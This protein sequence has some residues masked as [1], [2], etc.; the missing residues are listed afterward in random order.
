MN[1]VGLPIITFILVLGPLI[2]LHELGHFIALRLTGVTVLEFGIGFPPRAVKLFEQGGTIFSL[3]WLPIGGFVRPLGED[4]VRPV[5]EN[6]TEQDRAAFEK[7]QQELAL[8]GKKVVKTKSL[9]ETGPWQ[10]IFFFSAGIVMNLLTA[11]VLLVLVSMLGQPGPGIGIVTIASNSPAANAGLQ[12][13]DILVSIAGR[14]VSKVS[15]L[16]AKDISKLPASVPVVVTRKG[17]Q[18]TLTVAIDP[19]KTFVV[20]QQVLISEVAKDSPAEAGGLLAGDVIT[21]IDSKTIINVDDLVK[22]VT[23]HAGQKVTIYFQRDTDSKQVDL[24]PRTNPPAGQGPI[25][26]SIGGTTFYGAFGWSLVDTQLGPLVRRPLGPAVVDGFN[27]TVDNVKA[28]FGAPFALIAGRIR[29]QDARPGSI[30]AIS[31][32]GSLV[33]QQSLKAQ[34][35]YPILRFAALIS[36]SL[37]FV[38]LLPI[39]GLD[40]GRILF[41]LIELLRGKPMDPEREGI[42]HMFGL[43][44]LLVLSAVLI[45]NDLVNPITNSLPK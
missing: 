45:L 37:A 24:V 29:P 17:E 16:A 8:L 14:P 23:D 2:F 28:V 6:A 44:A 12:P 41:V 33:L 32:I 40:G 27:Q 34:E 1:N 4:F 38:N 19:Q 21:K 25:G 43:L 10:R 20:R 31:Q 35:P 26:I 3:N 15:D 11:F 9:Q 13:D 5:G 30:V 36:I 22:Y 42:V 39:P 18:Q 7:Y